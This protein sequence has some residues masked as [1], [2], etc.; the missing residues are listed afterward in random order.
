MGRTTKP[1]V[2]SRSRKRDARGGASGKELTGLSEALWGRAGK[3]FGASGVGSADAAAVVPVVAE[4]LAVGRREVQTGRVRISKQVHERREEV[5]QPT[6][7]EDVVVE[8][9]PVNGVVDAAP[10]PR[11]EGDTWIVPVTE[12]VV[13]VEK[14]LVLKE[15]VRITKRRTESHDPRT[16]T[17]RTEEVKIDRMSAE[18]GGGGT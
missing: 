3:N 18:S 7:T 15:E 17:L 10:A 14:R 5:D 16:V 2:L 9:V 12:E 1:K 4:E 13:V 6:V 8:R 11:Q